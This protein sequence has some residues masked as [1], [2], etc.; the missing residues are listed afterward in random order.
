MLIEQYLGPQPPETEWLQVWVYN[1]SLSGGLYADCTGW[2]VLNA[3]DLLAEVL[4]ASMT[5]EAKRKC[6]REF[7]HSA[8]ETP[9]YMYQPRYISSVAHA[10]SGLGRQAEASDVPTFAAVLTQWA[11]EPNRPSNPGLAKQPEPA[12]S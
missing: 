10:I 1:R 3:Q 8:S 2:T 11:N 7:Q 6:L 12:G 5:D 9:V 4:N